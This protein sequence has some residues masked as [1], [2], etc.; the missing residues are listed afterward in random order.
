MG[1]DVQIRDLSHTYVSR[2]GASVR[3]LDNIN[4][5]ILNGEFIAVVGPSGCGKSTLLNIIAGLLKP[6]EGSVLVDGAT[7]ADALRRRQLGLVFQD[8][9]LLPWRDT[10]GNIQLP[11]ELAHLLEQRKHQVQALI[12]SVML[13]GFEHSYPRE[14]SGGMRSR[15]AIARALVLSPSLLLMDEP[16]GSLDEITA[17]NL[18]L[19]LLRIW[20]ERKPTVLFVTHSISQAVFMADRVIVLSPRPGRVLNDVRVD[21]PRPRTS[22][23]LGS[24]HFVELNMLVRR[25]M[26][27]NF[28]PRDIK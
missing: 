2:G 7:V 26:V 11:L 8:P 25:E 21:I 18:N 23:T 3:A 28:Q 4:L 1:S 6:S 10:K 14:L 13:R 12:D 16:F 19:E 9:V 24:Q 5:T 20:E 22:E 15:V 27:T 17:H